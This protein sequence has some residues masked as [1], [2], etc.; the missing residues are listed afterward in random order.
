MV[1]VS[2]W[3]TKQFCLCLSRTCLENTNLTDRISVSE[4]IL[5]CH[6]EPFNKFPY[7]VLDQVWFFFSHPCCLK[8]NFTALVIRNLDKYSSFYFPIYLFIYYLVVY[9]FEI[10]LCQVSIPPI[11][12]I[13][14]YPYHSNSPFL[15][16]FQFKI[17]FCEYKWL[18]LCKIFYPSLYQC[19]I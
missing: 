13:L 12:R 4:F 18:E 5:Y 6:T 10:T 11:R 8:R 2:S 19:L 16:P 17:Q 14:H 3:K 9:L 1:Y 15:S 7:S